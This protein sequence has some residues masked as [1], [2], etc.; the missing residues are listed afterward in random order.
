MQLDE[1]AGALDA[2]DGEHL[3]PG[4]E[5][6]FVGAPTAFAVARALR[7]DGDGGDPHFHLIVRQRE[8]IFIE[9]MG[10]LFRFQPD[11]LAARHRADCRGARAIGEIAEPI[12]LHPIARDMVEQVAHRVEIE[13]VREQFRPASARREHLDRHFQQFMP[14][15]EREGRW[16]RRELGAFAGCGRRFASG[17]R[18]GFASRRWRAGAGAASPCASRWRSR[19]MAA[20]ARRRRSATGMAA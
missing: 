7:F 6:Q 5:G 19:S 16:R 3:L 2:P 15:G 9:R 4:G 10:G 1:F 20:I 18:S 12:N 11:V 17:G 14:D 8:Q 13:F